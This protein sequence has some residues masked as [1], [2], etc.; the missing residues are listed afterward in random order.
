MFYQ[1]GKKF[2]NINQLTAYNALQAIG[3]TAKQYKPASGVQTTNPVFKPDF[4]SLENVESPYQTYAAPSA[5]AA[6]EVWR[7]EDY[8]KVVESNVH[9]TLEAV[10]RDIE[11]ADFSGMSDV[12]IYEYIE[13]LFIEAFGEDYNMLTPC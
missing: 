8:Y 4:T 7:I 12:E 6:K 11:E 3:T 9:A 13:N 5:P 10:Y 1:G 2:V